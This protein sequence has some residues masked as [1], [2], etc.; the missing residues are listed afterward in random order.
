MKGD[1]MRNRGTLAGLLLVAVMGVACGGGS[2]G[3][4]DTGSAGG[5]D[6]GSTTVTASDFVFEPTSVSAAA[7]GTIEFIN[8]DDAEH[9][10]TADDPGIDVDAGGGES[11][12]VEVDAEPGTYDFYCK[13][14]EDMKGTLEVTS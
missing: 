3:A 5:G 12:T 8:E 7:G 6:A 11:V 13:Y 2:E 9:S 1:R 14:H 10:F 4:D